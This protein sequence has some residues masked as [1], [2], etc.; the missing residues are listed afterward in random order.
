MAIEVANDGNKGGKHLN[1][2][3]KDEFAKNN[4]LVFYDTS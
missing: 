2:R 3:T 4:E 1:L